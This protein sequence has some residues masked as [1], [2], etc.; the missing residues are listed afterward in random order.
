MTET[1]PSIKTISMTFYI[2]QLVIV[3]LYHWF[4]VT[5][6]CSVETFFFA[7]SVEYL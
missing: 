1:T 6:S 2:L 7:V 5:I 3:K 4:P